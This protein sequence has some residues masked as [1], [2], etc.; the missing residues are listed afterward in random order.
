MWKLNCEFSLS[1][2]CFLDSISQCEKLPIIRKSLVTFYPS[3]GFHLLY[4]S[5]YIIYSHCMSFVPKTRWISWNCNYTY[6]FTI[7][8]YKINMIF[9]LY[10]RE[11]SVIYDMFLNV[12]IY[13]K[14]PRCIDNYYKWGVVLLCFYWSIF[15]V[16]LILNR[17]TG[18]FNGFSGIAYAFGFIF[19]ISRGLKPV[20]DLVCL[21]ELNTMYCK[22]SASYHFNVPRI[23][24]L[25]FFSRS[26]SKMV[27][28]NHEHWICKWCWCKW[29]QYLSLIE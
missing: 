19:L 2:F 8:I 9:L 6:Y 13:L 27:R 29:T 22:F 23:Y 28:T 20:L 7:N 11:S 18:S 1:V 10:K 15:A 5:I 21:S 14:K 25:N 12:N 3:R 24:I 26:H 16:F 4:L 17:D